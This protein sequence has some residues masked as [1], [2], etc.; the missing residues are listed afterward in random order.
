MGQGRLLSAAVPVEADVRR[1][2]DT[3]AM[4]GNGPGLYLPGMGEI[5]D[6][7]D[8]V[9]KFNLYNLGSRPGK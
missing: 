4:V 6:R 2:F 3:C 9:F 8:A 7:H 1:D 5:I